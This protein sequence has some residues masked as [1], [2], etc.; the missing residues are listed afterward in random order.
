MNLVVVLGCADQGLSYELRSQLA[1]IGDVE[2]A[3]VAESTQELGAAVLRFAPDV[4]FLHD[5][6]GPQP[7]LDVMRDLSL[8]RPG[9]A[10]IVVS[11]DTDPE[12]RIEAMEAGARGIVSYPLS[13]EE[14]QLRIA[15]AANW[16]KTMQRLVS[17]DAGGA[18]A[19][20]GA[21]VIVMTGA[22]GGVGVTTL[23]LHFALDIVSQV[24]GHRVILV[25]LDLEKGDV[26]SLL[27]VRYHTSVADL[28][29]VADDLSSRTV[30]DA[31]VPHDSGLVILPAPIDVRDVEHVSPQ[32]IRRILALMRQHYDLILVDAG[33][34]V[35]PVQAAAV[36]LA[37]EVIVVT[38]ADVLSLRALRRLT[39]S[40]EQ[41]GVRKPDAVRVLV[42]KVSRD[43][44]V[45]AETVRRLAQAPVISVALPAL[46]RRL[47]VAVNSRDPS[48]MKEP[49]WFAALR[50]IGLE[51]GMVRLPD[52]QGAAA[53]ALTGPG[54]RKRS[55]SAGRSPRSQSRA[56]IAPLPSGRTSPSRT[57]VVPVPT[58]SSASAPGG[59]TSSVGV[60][61][62]SLTRR[63]RRVV[64]APGAGVQA[65]TSRSTRSAGEVQSTRASSTVSLGASDTPSAGCGTGTSAP[66][67]RASRAATSRPAPLRA[68]RSS[69]SPLV[70]VGRTVSV[71]TP[72]TGPVSRPSSSTKAVAPVV[73]SP[74]S[75]ACCTGA[76]PRQAGSSEKCR[77]TQPWRG[78]SSAD[79]GT[80][81]P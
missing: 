78:T 1:E 12:V 46:F 37:E 52:N 10:T 5:E 71:T 22:K 45:Q 44:E 7:Y 35:T 6:L 74:A 23:A 63:S 9:T 25:D 27:D 53:A 20:G 67:S 48:A 81:A 28:A 31:V 56:A 2:V 19:I 76:A 60:T 42:N 43:D 21:R 3:F 61:G 15:N 77:L 59:R 11:S 29:K 64:Q 30:L 24:P 80:S 26:S 38:T 54:H 75:S 62:P 70:S 32:A 69:R 41:L 14:I 40:W 50:A 34:H 66:S 4:V 13:F 17:G 68:S 57:A 16:A 49:V 55:P 51:T 33:S 79:R 8:R 72:S 39:G 47:E 73:S 18:D 65:R 36:E 58:R